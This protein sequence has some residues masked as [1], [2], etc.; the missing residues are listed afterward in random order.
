MSNRDNIDKN[1]QDMDEIEH[2]KTYLQKW[3]RF[4]IRLRSYHSKEKIKWNFMKKQL[5]QIER[6]RR[7]TSN[8]DN[9]NKN[10]QD[11]DN[12]GKFKKYGQKWIRFWIRQFMSFD[13]K[14]Y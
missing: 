10:S 5:S 9:I 2:F 14:K 7:D 11:M 1:G 8:C 4:W 13:I 6:A 3:I 12:I